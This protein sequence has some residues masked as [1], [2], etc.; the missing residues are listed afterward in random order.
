MKKTRIIIP[1]IAMIAFSTVASIA[2][3]VAWFTANRTANFNAGTYAVVKTTANLKCEVTG[4]IA[5][6]ADSSNIVTVNGVLTDGSFNHKTGNIYAPNAD[7]SAIGSEIALASAKSDNTLLERGTTSDSKTI[8]TAVTFDIKFTVSFGSASGNYGL[9][10]DNTT[11]KTSF[12]TSDS[13]TPA[14]AKGFRMAFYPKS[15]TT[16]KTVLAD[17]QDNGTWDHDSDAET[18]AVNKIRYVNATSNYVGTDYVAGDYDL[19]NSGYNAALPDSSATYAQA[20]NRADYLG[21]F[22]FSANADVVIEYTVV[23]WFEGTDP[24]IVNRANSSEYQSVVANL[25]FAAVAIPAAS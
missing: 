5:T 20:T 22:T 1:A 8:Y 10:L 21:Q 24:E 13:S 6:S 3:S 23:A 16:R 14:T 17:L 19:M 25:Y 11:G 2:G 4:G 9:Y 12:A 7:G 18:A 15:G